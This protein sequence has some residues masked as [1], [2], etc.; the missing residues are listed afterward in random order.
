MSALAI[1]VCICICL[2]FDVGVNAT[3]DIWLEWVGPG[4]ATTMFIQEPETNTR[5]YVIVW[6][7]D[8]IRAS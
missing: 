4:T 7:A 3:S 5:D 1:V 2:W 6:D 8:M